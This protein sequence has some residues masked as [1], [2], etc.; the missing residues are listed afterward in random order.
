M[1][2]VFVAL[3]TVMMVAIV[4]QFFLAAMSA[5]DTAP[6]EESFELHRALGY[7]IL[8][9]AVVL[10]L[11]AALA[12]MPGRLIGMTGLAGGLVLL[13]AVIATIA[14]ALA[15]PAG[16]S[17][18]AG[19]LVF[20]LHAVNALIIFGVVEDVQRRSRELTGPRTKNESASSAGTRASTT[21]P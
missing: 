8:L 17:S 6:K 13:Q 3:A 18:T 21:A 1:R 12:R 19:K 7:G 14:N 4:A 15:D 2:R 10:T 5:F 11:L 9:L 20:G 16:A